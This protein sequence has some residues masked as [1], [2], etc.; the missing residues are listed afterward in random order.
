VV[1]GKTFV[2]LK[3]LLDGLSTISLLTPSLTL[4][5]SGGRSGGLREARWTAE[6]HALVEEPE[7]ALGSWP[8][9]NGAPLGSGMGLPA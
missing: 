8:A 7:E 5:D 3:E 1:D 6:E 4:T 9:R 2:R